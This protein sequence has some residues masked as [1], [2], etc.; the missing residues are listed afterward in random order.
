MSSFPPD[1]L[2][3]EARQLITDG[4]F[5]E[6]QEA[7]LAYFQTLAKV[8]P[9]KENEAALQSAREFLNWAI[10]AVAAMRSHALLRRSELSRTIPYAGSGQRAFKTWEILS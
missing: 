6:A 1:V 3:A 8:E 5:V 9:L 10:K 4:H 7:V 2:A